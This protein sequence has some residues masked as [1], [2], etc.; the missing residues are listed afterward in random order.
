MVEVQLGE[1]G[2]R[3]VLLQHTRPSSDGDQLFLFMV[4]VDSRR[5]SFFLAPLI[6]RHGKGAYTI[7]LF[8]ISQPKA[9][10]IQPLSGL[11]PPSAG[12][13]TPRMHQFPPG[14]A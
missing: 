6:L 4:H 8:T 1:N 14:K 2:K 13:A 12:L 3:E 5:N 10:N 11:R 7:K 9:E